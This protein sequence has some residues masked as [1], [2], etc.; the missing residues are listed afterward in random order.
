MRLPLIETI[1]QAWMKQC[2]LYI[3]S[4]LYNVCDFFYRVEALDIVIAAILWDKTM[5]QENNESIVL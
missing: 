2:T 3:G 1:S 4:T 5:N